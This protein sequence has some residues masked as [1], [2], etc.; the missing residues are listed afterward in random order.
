MTNASF[1]RRACLRRPYG[2]AMTLPRALSEKIYEPLKPRGR[3]FHFAVRFIQ[4]EVRYDDRVR[5]FPA[6][7][8]ADGHLAVQQGS[9]CSDGAVDHG[10]APNRKA[11]SSIPP[12]PKASPGHGSFRNSEAGR[13]AVRPVP[14]QRFHQRAS[15]MKTA[16]GKRCATERTWHGRILATGLRL[17]RRGGTRLA[18]SAHWR[19][20]SPYCR[21]RPSAPEAL[22]AGDRS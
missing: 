7:P 9:A 16:V 5:C 6:W 3:V 11:K 22:S 12:R 1:G 2:A 4:Q 8:C 14:F 20:G 18:K 21:C 13:A 10:Q 17:P 19:N 15:A